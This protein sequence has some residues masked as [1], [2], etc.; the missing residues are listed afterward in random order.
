MASGGHMKQWHK[1]LPIAILT[2][3]KTYHSSLDCESCRGFHGRVPHKILDHKLGL[4]FNPNIAPTTDFA[5][6]LLRRTKIFYDKTKKNVMQS[7]VR[8]KN[9]YDK[10]AKDSRLNGKDYCFILQPKTDHLGS[11]TI[12]RYFCLIGFCLV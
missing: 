11:K 1:N 10:K 2:Y 6:E 8:Y 5:D 12:F 7:Y 3:Y 4:R 9:Y